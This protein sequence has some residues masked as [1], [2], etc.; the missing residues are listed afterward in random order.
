[1]RK[2][3]FCKEV[4]LEPNTLALKQLLKFVKLYV[5]MHVYTHYL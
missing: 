3:Y 4:F 5:I 1:M 2:E